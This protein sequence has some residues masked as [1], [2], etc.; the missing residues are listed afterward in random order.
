[1]N[2]V[3]A[4]ATTV[5]GLSFRCEAPVATRRPLLRCRRLDE[6]ASGAAARDARSAVCLSGHHVT[7]HMQSISGVTM[8]LRHI[9]R[10][11]R[12]TDTRGRTR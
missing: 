8:G 3:T 7:A 2:E 9:L 6:A 10:R 4:R 1:M 11:G 12:L 5:T